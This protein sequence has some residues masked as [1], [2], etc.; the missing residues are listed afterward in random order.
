MPSGPEFLTTRRNLLRTFAAGTALLAAPRSL[1]AVATNAGRFDG[2]T[3]V[4]KTD[5]MA[6]LLTPPRPATPIW[7]YNGQAPGPVLRVKQGERLN[8]RL[9]NQLDHPTTIHWHGLRLDNAMDGVPGLTQAAVEPGQSFD[10]SFVCPDAGTFWYHPHKMASEQI[11]RGLHGMLIVDEVDPPEVDQDLVL[12]FDDWRLQRDGQ[13]HAESFGEI[14]ER[15]HGGRYGNVYT[16]N[17]QQDHRVNAR[18]GERL[19]LRLCNV[20]NANIFGLRINQHRMRVI[21][22]DGQPVDPFE[23]KDDFLIIGT[24]QRADVIVDLTEK[25]GTARPITVRALQHEF[26]VGQIAYHQTERARDSVLADDVVLEPNPLS[27]SLAHDAAEKVFLHM[28]GGAMG[29]MRGAR[30]N[31]TN[32]RIGDL[33]ERFG[34]VWAFNGHAGMPKEPLFRVKTG[35]TVELTFNNATGWPHAMHVHGHHFKHLSSMPAQNAS[36]GSGSGNMSYQVPVLNPGWRDTILTAPR[37]AVKIGFVADNPGK[38]MMHCHMLEHHEGG[39]ATWFEV[40]G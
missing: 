13:I 21:A 24:G 25:P 10:Y 40:T 37:E 16:L 31:Q 18:A 7:G 34:Y 8:V 11:A 3:I 20:S 39:M 33:V 35:T 2:T 22:L 27:T 30:V 36:R 29:G 19:R 38:W 28:D 4:A 15:A 26:T 9:L 14:A 12:V 1:R 32:Y 23:A 5:A 6:S 17:G